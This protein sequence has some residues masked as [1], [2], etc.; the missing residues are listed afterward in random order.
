MKKQVIALM[1]FVLMFCC[2][3]SAAAKPHIEH[4]GA[5]PL[6]LSSVHRR[7]YA[8]YWDLFTAYEWGQKAAEYAAGE[9]RLRKLEA[10]NKGLSRGEI[11]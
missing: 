4:V 3:T 5:R 6:D 10:I 8:V 11:V 2:R 9:A 1:S 7:T